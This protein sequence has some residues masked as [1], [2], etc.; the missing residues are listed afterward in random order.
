M[1]GLRW[2]GSYSPAAS[3]ISLPARFRK[4][5]TAF[6]G[7]RRLAAAA[8]AT[9]NG[10]VQEKPPIPND[11]SESPIAKKADERP[12][13]E[14]RPALAEDEK[15]SQSESQKGESEE[16]L[17]INESDKAG[18]KM[19]ILTSTT[20]AIS[21]ETPIRRRQRGPRISKHALFQTARQLRGLRGPPPPSF[22]QLSAKA[23]Q[24]VTGSL[25]SRETAEKKLLESLLHSLVRWAAVR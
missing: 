22:G 15:A 8:P 5:S 16:F 17:W 13:S 3:R 4:Q 25:A 23:F 14:A 10:S 12:P 9:Q 11:G 24:P 7:G 20:T 6:S 1:P 2:P 18:E 21:V 19:P